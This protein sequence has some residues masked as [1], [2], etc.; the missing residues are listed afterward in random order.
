MAGASKAI[1]DPDTRAAALKQIRLAKEFSGIK[2]VLLVDHIN[3]KAFG[4]NESEQDH[5][6]NLLEAKAIIE[7][8]IN[9]KVITYLGVVKP[10]GDF[11]LQLIEGK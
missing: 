7:Q 9:V 10:N 1:T 5:V 11:K 2:I 8:G 4:G 6:K 3:C